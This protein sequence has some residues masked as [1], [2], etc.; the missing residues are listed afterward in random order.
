MFDPDDFRQYKWVPQGASGDPD[1]TCD[2]LNYYI[3][4]F[5]DS[6]DGGDDNT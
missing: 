5:I 3:M 2:I 1:P 4:K 6:L